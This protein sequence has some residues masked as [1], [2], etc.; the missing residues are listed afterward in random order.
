MNR[1][2]VICEDISFRDYRKVKCGVPQAAQKQIKDE[3][4]TLSIDSI[5]KFSKDKKNI[6]SD[7]KRKA[8]TREMLLEYLD[9]NYNIDDDF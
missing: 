9:M 4:E 3:P 1:S 8:I 2:K 5:V 7:R 6:R